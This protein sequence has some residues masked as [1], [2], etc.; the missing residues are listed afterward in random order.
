MP[1]ARLR[2][3]LRAALVGAGVVLAVP[4]SAAADGPCPVR[5][6]PEDAAPAWRE[7]V[8]LAVARVL[9]LSGTHDCRAVEVSVGPSGSA[10]LAFLTTDGRGAARSLESPAELAPTLE[11]L[12]VTQVAPAEP[13]APP[14]PPAPS[15]GGAPPSP[16]VTRPAPS[17]VRPAPAAPPPH[18]VA[19]YVRATGGTRLAWSP[20]THLAPTLALRPSLGVG[21]WE[22]GAFVDYVPVHEPVAASVPA[23]FALSS[24]ATGIFFGARTR[25][26]DWLL[27]AGGALGVK[28]VS[29]EADDVPELALSR[30][31]DVAQPSLGAYGKASYP[32]DSRLR[33]VTELGFDTILG[34]PR[35]KATDERRLPGLPRF[36]LGL[37][38]GV[39]ATLL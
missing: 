17:A 30:T 13:A 29:E 36:G 28:S 34:R 6:I 1:S 11:A 22:L 2:S 26:G 23:G 31:V 5:L 37:S 4:L 35:T 3:P 18:P 12:L 20:V 27:G 38:L 14:P 25:A 16:V 32:A 21:P 10:T 8:E 33:F 24:L 39:E 9:R 15:P 7:A 19:L